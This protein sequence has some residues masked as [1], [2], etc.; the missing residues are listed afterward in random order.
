M[1]NTIT[2]KITLSNSKRIA[3][4]NLKLLTSIDLISRNKKAIKF[5]YQREEMVPTTI[6]SLSM[7]PVKTVY[8]LVVNFVKRIAIYVNLRLN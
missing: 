8:C 1:N 5:P 2:I 7:F 3:L 6:N 4:I